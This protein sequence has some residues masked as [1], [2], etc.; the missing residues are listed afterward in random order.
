MK[1]QNFMD[2][3]EILEKLQTERME[4]DRAIFGIGGLNWEAPKPATAV[5]EAPTEEEAIPRSEEVIE[6]RDDFRLAT[7]RSLELPG[8]GLHRPR[9]WRRQRAH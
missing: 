3:C 2:I 9:I 4:I 8:A 5:A 6:R 1:N 7:R